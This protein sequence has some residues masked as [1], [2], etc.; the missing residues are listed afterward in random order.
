[1]SDDVDTNDEL[2]LPPMRFAT[3]RDVQQSRWFVSESV[4][5]DPQPAQDFYR[6]GY[7]SLW[8]GN[9]ADPRAFELYVEEP[10]D[11]WEFDEYR[12]VTSPL[13]DDLGFWVNYDMLAALC[14]PNPAAIETLI[15]DLPGADGYRGM[16]IAALR[17]N[18]IL[19]ADSLIALHHC[20]Y[21][22][23]RSLMFDRLRFAGSFTFVKG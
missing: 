15:A 13:E 6:P 21:T 11:W 7:V 20:D 10:E 18:G 1:V 16:L 8:I 5:H 14:L 23:Q 17:A 19:V 22:G 4:D 2:P 3:K 12:D 9:V